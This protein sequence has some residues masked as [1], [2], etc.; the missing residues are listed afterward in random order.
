MTH[1][2]LTLSFL[3]V[4]YT[5]SSTR[6]FIPWAD[7]TRPLAQSLLFRVFHNPGEKAIL[8]PDGRLFYKQ[9]VRY[10][11]EPVDLTE[12]R[13]AIRDFREQLALRGIRLIVVPI[14]VKPNS[15]LNPGIGDIDLL[16]LI[17]NR[18]LAYDTHWTCEG[19]QIAAKA[20]ADLLPEFRGANNY[21][22]KPV[23]VERK[24]DIVRMMDSPTLERFFPPEPVPCQQVQGYKDDL[25]SPILVLGD[26]FLR[27]YQTDAPTSAG[28]IAHLARELR[29]PLASIVNDGG[30]STLVRQE[31]ARKSD[32]LKGKKVVIWEFVERDLRFGVEGW[33]IVK[34]PE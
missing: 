32:L 3:A 2:L 34:I 14:P 6:F 15:G 29:M 19:A 17:H 10:L 12:P 23:T 25:N 21:D 1:K 9:D 31:L 8:A 27:I 28:F 5:I 7:K 16:P 13:A 24:G 20:V 30:A 22:V 18:Y 4:I 26:S 33:Q 11:V